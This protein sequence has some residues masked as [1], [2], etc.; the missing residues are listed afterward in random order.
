MVPAGVIGATAGGVIIDRLKLEY[1]RIVIIQFTVS[2]VVSFAA[3]MFL[4]RC[5]QIKFAGVNVVYENRY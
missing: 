1:E 3:L 4:I 5:D 2:I